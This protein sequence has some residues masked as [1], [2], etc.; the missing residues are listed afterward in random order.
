MESYWIFNGS[1]IIF[2]GI[3]AIIVYLG[4]QSPELKEKIKPLPFALAIAL[5]SGFMVGLYMFMSV[6]IFFLGYG[7]IELWKKHNIKKKQL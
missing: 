7:V 6:A 1:T 4:A 2:F 3:T 5:S